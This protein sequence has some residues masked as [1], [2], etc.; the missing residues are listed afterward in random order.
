MRVRASSGEKTQS[1]RAQ[2]LVEPSAQRMLLTAYTPLGTAALTLFAE[3]DRVVFLDHVNK[4]AWEGA[5]NNL[6]QLLGVLGGSP[7]HAWALVM[8]G[9]GSEMPGVEIRY[10]PPPPALPQ[11][12]TLRRG[13][14]RVEVAISDLISTDAVPERPRIPGDYRCCVA[15][16]M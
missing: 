3:A 4:T 11:R 2:L 15:P 9:Y 14:D 1:F 8:V 16:R 10:D 5:A 7:P 13:T 12:V 6:S